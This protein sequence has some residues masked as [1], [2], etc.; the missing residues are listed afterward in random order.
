MRLD[1]LPLALELAAARLRSM[2]VSQIA[3]R[4]DDRFRLLTAGSRT[5]MPRHRTLRAVVEWSW[6]LLEK[7]ERILARRLSVFAAG[8]TL[9]AAT[10]VCSDDDL[11]AA[12]VLYVLASLVEKSLVEAGGGRGGGPRL[13]LRG[14]ALGPA[15]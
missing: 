13:R 5:S 7:P 6:D 2:T 8:T 11:P 4:L 12:D 3:E 9:E 1:G 14:H 15:P 10:S